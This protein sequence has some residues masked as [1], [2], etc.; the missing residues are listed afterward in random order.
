MDWRPPA[1]PF[2][3]LVWLV[4]ALG[5]GYAWAEYG[6]G[7]G[8]VA[9]KVALMLAALAGMVASVRT[10]SENG[11]WRR[12]TKVFL[13]VA[14]VVAGNFYYSAAAARADI[15]AG[16]VAPRESSVVVE[17]RQR[18]ALK[19]E[20]GYAAGVGVIVAAPDYDKEIVGNKIAYACAWKLPQ[21][22]ER[23][24]Q[25]RM[26]GIVEGVRRGREGFEDYLWGQHVP[27][28]M[29]R[30]VAVGIVNDAPWPMKIVEASR[31]WVIK[32]LER[33]EPYGA[34]LL[35]AMVMG[36]KA[37]M[38]KNQTQDFVRSGTYHLVAVSGMN[39][40]VVAALLWF[41]A[42]AVGMPLATAG[43]VVVGVL[44]FYAQVTGATASVMRAWGMVTLAVAAAVS[45]RQAN[46]WPIVVLAAA[47]SLLLEPLSLWHGGWR[48]SFGVVAGMVLGMGALERWAGKSWPR[49]FGGEVLKAL[50]VSAVAGLAVAPMT[51]AYWGIA[52]PWGFVLNA[53]AVALAGWVT[54]LG[55][56]S[57]LLGWLP[58]VSELLNTA[59][60]WIIWGIEWLIK[61]YLSLPGS[62]VEVPWWP[63]W[64]GGVA[65][66]VLLSL[67]WVA[68]WKV[69][70]RWRGTVEF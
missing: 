57:I 63:D 35:P 34:G 23:G 16:S 24:M 5:I 26:E 19:E 25:V 13:W 29:R 22:C 61:T 46:L 3:P 14:L 52:Q 49:G 30:G 15:A 21:P 4:T 59:A 2:A 17:I 70:T 42:R 66:V 8:G 50:A 18:F 65:T 54:L 33:G 69:Q 67:L 44:Y 64:A 60:G 7:V 43:V 6:A 27:F 58:W 1:R 37:E 10:K 41:I 56:V 51:A 9:S 53:A 55:S 32:T 40:M 48:L 11:Q 62:S 45:K 12:M 20:K 31:R 68:A 36:A 28:K 47:G 38:T 39:V